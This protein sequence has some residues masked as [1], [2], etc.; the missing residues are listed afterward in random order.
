VL[1]L[2]LAVFHWINGFSGMFVLS[3]IF[4]LDERFLY[5]KGGLFLAIYWYFWF[6]DGPRRN[7]D[8]RT[9]V[10]VLTGSM[11][12]IFVNRVISM[13]APFRPR[14]MYD[15]ASGWIPP[16]IVLDLKLDHWS[17]F[18]SDTASFFVALAFGLWFLSRPAAVIALPL[19]VLLV[20]L[21]RVY[22]GF[23]YPGDIVVGGLIGVAAVSLS[24]RFGGRALG[25]VMLIVER[26][27]RALFYA[28]FFFLSYELGLT[29][30]N[31]RTL[32]IGI[33]KVLK[34]E[35]ST[36]ELALIGVLI[37]G[38]AAAAATVLALIWRA[39]SQERAASTRVVG[40]ASFDR[41]PGTDVEPAGPA[42]LAP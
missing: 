5:L 7:E 29:F 9:I 25:D 18:P 16:Q 12:A 17:A 15:A 1:E 8:R 4:A 19:T 31:A 34:N 37:A 42:R 23:H 40:F 6:G 13:A 41:G 28:L 20:L 3:R 24:L 38:I 2:D 14:P 33:A 22:F 39:W 11:L 32:A 26:R 21:P 10:A 36:L 27:Q 35:S 30:Q